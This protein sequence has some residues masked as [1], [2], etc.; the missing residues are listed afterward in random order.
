[1]AKY[2][3]SFQVPG[4]IKRTITHLQA[5]AAFK[6]E[7]FQPVAIVVGENLESIED[8][9]VVINERMYRVESPLR[10]V[11]VTFKVFHS[12]HLQ[13]PQQSEVLWM[14]LQKLVYGLNTAWDRK[15]TALSGLMSSLKNA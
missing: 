12:L 1:L 14:L 3:L 2:E 6:K 5:R 11:D 15:S 8:S 7:T 13:Y 9:Y 10:A 4:E